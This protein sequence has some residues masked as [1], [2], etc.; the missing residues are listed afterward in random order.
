MKSHVHSNRCYKNQILASLPEDAMARLEPSLSH[1]TL[2]HNHSLLEDGQAVTAAYFLE[3][4][5]A[6][7]VVTTEDG[8]T[9]EAGIVGRFG[10]VGIP[11]LLGEHAGPNFH[12][13]TRF[14]L[15]HLGRESTARI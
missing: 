1:T 2:K 8:K 7:I 13:D 12:P 9:V 10:M 11:I 4:G 5:I 14:W 3:E 6:S 15:S